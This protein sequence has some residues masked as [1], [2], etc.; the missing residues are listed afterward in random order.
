MVRPHVSQHPPV[1]RPGKETAMRRPLLAIATVL[2]FVLASPCIAHSADDNGMSGGQPLILGK[3]THMTSH[4]IVVLTRDGE[5][6]PIEFDSRTV[7]T[8]TMPTGCRVRVEFRLLDN[9]RYLAQRITPLERGSEAWAALDSRRASRS[10]SKLQGTLPAVYGTEAQD[11][12]TDQT[13]SNA[14]ES[15]T[16]GEADASVASSDTAT[17]RSMPSALPVFLGAGLLLIVGVLLLRRVRR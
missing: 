15:V 16:E 9:G 4:S 5:S 11:V 14:S 13:A 1:Q 3:V 2:A 17:Q 7:M 12:K 10:H 8:T 6:L